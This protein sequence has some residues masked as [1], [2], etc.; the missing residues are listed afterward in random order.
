MHRNSDK[1]TQ[2]HAQAYAQG[3]DIHLGPGQEKYLPYKLG[4]VLQQK[5]NSVKP[6]VQIKG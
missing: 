6:T 4:H 1:P 3:S 2:L 5:E